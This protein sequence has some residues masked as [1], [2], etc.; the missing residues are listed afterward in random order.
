[1]S[2]NLIVGKLKKSKRRNMLKYTSIVI[3]QG[4]FKERIQLTKGLLAI[5]NTAPIKEMF[6]NLYSDLVF[7][8]DVSFP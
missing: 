8:F 6:D 3:K 4:C 2:N 5:Q 1:M 7:Y